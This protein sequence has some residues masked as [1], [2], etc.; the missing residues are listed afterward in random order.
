MIRSNEVLLIKAYENI[1]HLK[2]ISKNN[3][4]LRLLLEKENKKVNLC[5]FNNLIKME[6]EQKLGNES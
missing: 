1:F 6:T 3:Q 2:Y 5:D 4:S